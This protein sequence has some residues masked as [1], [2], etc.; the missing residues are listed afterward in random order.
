ML[1][2]LACQVCAAGHN[3]ERDGQRAATMAQKRS[4]RRACGRALRNLEDCSRQKFVPGRKKRPGT[5]N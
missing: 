5:N 2:L 1:I 3:P 4:F